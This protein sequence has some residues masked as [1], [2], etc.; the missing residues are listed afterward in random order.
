MRSKFGHNRSGMGN[1]QSICGH[2]TTCSCSHTVG[3]GGKHKHERN[4]VHRIVRHHSSFRA[5][6][7]SVPLSKSSWVSINDPCTRACLKGGEDSPC[8]WEIGDRARRHR[9]RYHSQGERFLPGCDDGTTSVGRQTRWPGAPVSQR[10][11]WRKQETIANNRSS[12][13]HHLASKQRQP[14]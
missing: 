14:T 7:A 1:V 5:L 6:T 4:Q 11:V 9:V 3:I 8:P 13:R 12:C 10:K 2:T